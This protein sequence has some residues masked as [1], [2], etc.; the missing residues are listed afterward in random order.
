MANF[1]IRNWRGDAVIEAKNMAVARGLYK[2]ASHILNT[3]NIIAPEDEGILKQTADVDVDPGAGKAS[4]FY[5]QKYA[6]RLHENPQYNFQ[7]KGQGKWLETTVLTE[8]K[9]VEAIL[10]DEVRNGLGG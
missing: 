5:V 3:A 10:A 2:G 4:V 1:K 6:P 8:G 9:M 7:G